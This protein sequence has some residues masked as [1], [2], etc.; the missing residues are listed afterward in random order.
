MA[1]PQTEPSIETQALLHA[2]KKNTV[3]RPVDIAL[4]WFCPVLLFTLVFCCMS[5]IIRFRWKFWAIVIGP[6]LGFVMCVG[7]SLKA[8]TQF[9]SLEPSRNIISLT[10]SLWAA[11]IAGAV[12]G[13][14]NYWHYAVNYYAIL[15]LATYVNIDPDTE[16]GQTY[17]DAGEI[18]FKE[19]SYVA[20]DQ[21]TAYQSN[22]IFCVAPIVRRASTNQGSTSQ[23]S[24]RGNF[25]VPTSGTVDFWAVGLNCCDPSGENFS[26]GASNNLRARAGLRLLRHDVRPFFLLAV[27]EWSAWLNVDVL[28]PLFFSWVEDPVL[29]IESSHENAVSSCKV[30]VFMSSIVSL[31]AA[32]GIPWLLR[33]A[34]IP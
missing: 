23:A 22:G 32:L 3:R 17:M 11:L 30:A 26:C 29:E 24:A 12:L 34:K 19:D 20:V 9:R 13:D 5:F 28:H 10:V 1:N 16:K 14:V 2:P 31:A 18:Y 25:A 6:V 8:H 33:L 27:Q 4:G 15:D 21:A 7:L